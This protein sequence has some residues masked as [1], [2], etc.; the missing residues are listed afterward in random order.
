MKH[1]A[2]VKIYYWKGRPNF[3]D[4]MT[5]LLL[6]K[7]SD[8]DSVWA[9][10]AD[11]QLV[12]VGS[13]LEHMP[14]SWAGVVAGAGKMHEK[15]V[16]DLPNA[17]FLAVRGPLSAKGITRNL[18]EADPALLADE[19][20]GYSDKKFDLGLVPHWSDTALAKDPRFAKFNPKIIDVTQDP[21]K[22]LREI[23][24]C[25]KIVTSSLHG[26]IVADAFIIPRR[27][28]LAPRMMSHPHQEGGD[29]KWRD[30]HASLGMQFQPGV[31]VTADPHKVHDLQHQLFEV[32]EYVSEIFS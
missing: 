25:K 3:G 10:P 14:S 21:L 1:A 27:I 13:I 8:L 4:R 6:R 17:K 22:V 9:S 19:L 18:Y 20:V 29:F 28:E 30:Y 5:E 32:F 12:M 7:F 24:Q 31:L 15:S 23:S 11:A 2:T 16:I 26:A